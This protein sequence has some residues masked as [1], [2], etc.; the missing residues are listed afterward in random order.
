M[1]DHGLIFGGMLNINISADVDHITYG[2]VSRHA[3]SHRIATFLRS[4]GMD[5]EVVDFIA[6]W[7][8]EEF[9][10]L[11]KSRVKPSTRFFGLGSIGYLNTPTIRMCFAW[12]KLTY[13]D[14]PFVT[15]SA[16][17]YSLHFIPSDYMVVGFGEYAILEIL[18]GT[19][20]YKEQTLPNGH[21]VKLVN[22]MEDYPAF[23]MSNLSIDYEKRDFLQPYESL[24]METS[25]G[26][27]FKCS[28]CTFSVLGVKTD[29]TRS[30]EDFRDNLKR[31]YDNYGIY[32]YSITDET[33][34]DHSAKI[35]KY[36]DVVEAL[37]FKP[38]F[39]G[40]IRADLLHTR[41]ED[42]EHLA[43]MNF[44]AHHY[45]IESFHRPSAAAIGKGM[46]P[47]KLKTAIL[48][49]KDYILKTMGFYKG[50]ISFIVGLPHE[51]EQSLTITKEWCD[52]HWRNENVAYLPLHI[53]SDFENVKQSVL[54]TSYD[55]Q[56]YTI[57]DNEEAFLDESH[58][59]IS[60]FLADDQI[61][62]DL[63]NNLRG[64]LIL[65]HPQN[66]EGFRWR[67]NMG[68]TE[69]D[70]ILWI[71]QNVWYDDYLKFGVD[72][73]R[74]NEWFVAGKTEQDLLGSYRDLGGV[75]ASYDSKI[76][77]IENYKLK[78]INY[79]DRFSG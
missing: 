51:T 20:K 44:N 67:N 73:W 10:E 3:G 55:K 2:S 68:M 70:A 54:T 71:L 66:I 27:I 21:V 59:V 58:P 13:P 43:R 52:Q 5:I 56:G 4:H 12:L 40:Y 7:K 46:D 36:A 25:R 18:K 37:D 62:I 8:F 34:N 65:V 33:F 57:I 45:G 76:N 39:G 42:K 19:A 35:I 61:P 48:D 31:N 78:K 9:Q 38:N 47:E 74:M 16:Q 79:R 24:T 53:A 29:H 15:G 75:R 60:K 14:I 69:K 72:H 30:A 1:K 11:I 23:P 22:A 17:F 49:T 6:S 63:K 32:R 50:T 26:C 77:F 41:P 28:F 64:L